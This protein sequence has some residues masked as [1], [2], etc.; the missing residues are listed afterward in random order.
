MNRHGVADI[1]CAGARTSTPTPVPWIGL[2]HR[3][4]QSQHRCGDL[5]VLQQCR[6]W[7]R[8][9]SSTRLVL[10]AYE[11]LPASWDK[12]FGFDWATLPAPIPARTSRTPLSAA[13][14]SLPRPCPGTS[15]AKSARRPASAIRRGARGQ[16]RSGLAAAAGGTVDVAGGVAGVGGRELDV[17]RGQLGRLA[18]S[19][20]R[21]LAAELLQLLLGLLC[22]P[23]Q[24]VAHRRW[25][26]PRR[27]SAEAS[28]RTPASSSQCGPGA[29]GAGVPTTPANCCG[30]RG[31]SHR[32]PLSPAA[33]AGGAEHP[34]REPMRLKRELIQIRA[35]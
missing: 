25:P 24:R 18:G 35:S 14:A 19:L 30:G 28:R 29:P 23:R 2:N 9:R 17:D 15:R 11:Q 20:Q 34:F 26:G 27:R 33:A 32:G 3:T 6:C 5:L 10:A 1:P 13:W 12:Y 16:A 4:C 8:G 22:H 31:A 21:R 7:L